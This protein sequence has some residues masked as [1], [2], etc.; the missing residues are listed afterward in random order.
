MKGAEAEEWRRWRLVEA[1]EA[2]DDRRGKTGREDVGRIVEGIVG[3][4]MRSTRMGLREKLGSAMVVGMERGSFTFP[5]DRLASSG[6]G[7]DLSNDCSTDLTE[8]H[9]SRRPP[10]FPASYLS[11]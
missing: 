5:N 4:R 3:P 7:R 1:S 6:R 10:C 2:T 11:F 9:P 8:F